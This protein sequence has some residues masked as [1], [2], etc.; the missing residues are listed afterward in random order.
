MKNITTEEVN[1]FVNKHYSTRVNL[2][3]TDVQMTGLPANSIVLYK[4]VKNNSVLIKFSVASSSNKDFSLTWTRE[5]VIP[6]EYS[7]KML[8]VNLEKK[9]VEPQKKEPALVQGTLF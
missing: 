4:D 5:F 7:D 9:K 8:F 3:E 6:N 1:S 2:G